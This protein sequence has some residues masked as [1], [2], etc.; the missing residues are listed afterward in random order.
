MSQLDQEEALALVLAHLRGYA[1][2]PEEARSIGELARL[3]AVA[4]KGKPPGAKGKPP[5]VP[6]ADQQLKDNASHDKSKAKKDAAKDAT[7]A[8]GLAQRFEVPQYAV[9]CLLFYVVRDRHRTH[10]NTKTQS[11]GHG[12][13]LAC[14]SPRPAGLCCTSRTSTIHTCPRAT[15]CQKCSRGVSNRPRERQRGHRRVP[16]P[17]L[18]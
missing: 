13:V 6:S 12:S 7:L 9:R 15:W 5:K 17:P 4:Y 11:S 1:L 3:A 8:A 2:L 14:L 16:Y 10:I 18:S